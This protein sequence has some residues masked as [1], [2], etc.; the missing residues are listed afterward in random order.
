MSATLQTPATD[1]ERGALAQGL[2]SAFG[3]E[4]PQALP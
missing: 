4:A 2:A 1:E 3:F